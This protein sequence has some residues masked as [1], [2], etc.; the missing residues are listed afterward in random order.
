MRKKPPVQIKIQNI[1]GRDAVCIL[2]E[3]MHIWKSRDGRIY[4]GT[5]PLTEAEA[6]VQLGFHCRLCDRQPICNREIHAYQTYGRN[7]DYSGWKDPGRVKFQFG[8]KHAKKIPWVLQNISN[9]GYTRMAVVERSAMNRIR[10][11]RLAKGYTQRE[12][13]RLVGTTQKRVSYWENSKHLPK[14]EYATKIMR[15]LE[16]GIEDLQPKE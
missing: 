16:C 14:L 10:E 4:K 12:L 1:L 7:P 13:G 6:Q 2:Y 5:E 9:R 11:F 3:H 8:T 15:V